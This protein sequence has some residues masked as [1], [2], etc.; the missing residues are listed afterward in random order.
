MSIFKLPE[1]GLL[2]ARLYMP[3]VRYSQITACRS[4]AHCSAEGR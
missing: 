3:P 4:A 2:V 1:A